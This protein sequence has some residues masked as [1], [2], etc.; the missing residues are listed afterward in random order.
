MTLTRTIRL[1]RVTTPDSISGGSGVPNVLN[2]ITVS[3]DGTRAYVAASKHNNLT[4][5][6]A[7][8]NIRAISSVIDLVNN[9]DANTDDTASTL[10]SIDFDNSG[11]PFGATFLRDGETLAFTFQGNDDVV[12]RTSNGIGVIGGNA[13]GGAPQGTCVTDQVL[14]INNATSRTVT[15]LDTYPITELGQAAATRLEMDKQ[16]PA[17]ALTSEELDGKR[18]FYSANELSQEN[19]MSCASCHVDGATD[20]R[21]R[22]ETGMEL[23]TPTLV[24]INPDTFNHIDPPHDE[25]QDTEH[26]IRFLMMGDG[27]APAISID[28]DSDMSLVPTAGAS[29]ALDNLAAYQ[30]HLA[31]RGFRSSFFLENGDVSVFYEGGRLLLEAMCPDCADGTVSRPIDERDVEVAIRE[32]GGDPFVDLDFML[33]LGDFSGLPADMR[34]V[35]ESWTPSQVNQVR[36][37]LRTR[38]Q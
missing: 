15:A 13:V 38:K 9:Q 20:D 33:L 2:S 1:N 28:A 16:I 23:R 12:F 19:Y 37:F 7:E 30:R 36:Y 10:N 29:T 25:F 5:P 4:V 32:A 27:L 21:I 34:A 22:L 18:I 14:Y 6:S 31:A 3:P 24:G 11:D 26:T 35:A 17:E 8:N